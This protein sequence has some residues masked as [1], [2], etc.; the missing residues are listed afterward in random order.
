MK[1]LLILLGVAACLGTSPAG[2]GEVVSLD[3]IT[4]DSEALDNGCTSATTSEQ[5]D[6]CRY[7]VCYSLLR[8]LWL[9]QEAEK[10]NLTPD[11]ETVEKQQREYEKSKVGDNLTFT[12]LPRLKFQREAIQLYRSKRAT[13]PKYDF[14]SLWSEVQTSATQLEI[15][16]RSLKA[17]VSAY[18]E[19]EQRFLEF[20]KMFPDDHESALQR[21]RNSWERE[22]RRVALEKALTPE[23]ELTSQELERAQKEYGAELEMAPDATNRM[24]EERKRAYY[25]NL[26]LRDH[27]SKDAKFADEEFRKGLLAWIDTTLIA[28][29]K[30]VFG[31]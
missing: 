9:L 10:R 5:P 17:L 28:P 18:G 12:V 15:P 24:L 23:D 8:S 4:L 25:V 30:K 3:S 14:A 16:E 27:I 29:D 6:E 1:K 7:R 20:Q 2:A 22:G 19:D 26:Y 31:K 13:N 11:A 21:T